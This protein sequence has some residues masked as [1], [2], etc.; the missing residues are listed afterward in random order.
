M[1]ELA[2]A[3]SILKL[4]M[5]SVL[6]ATSGMH[7]LRKQNRERMLAQNAMRSI[8]ERVH[9]RSHQLSLQSNTWAND[10]ADMFGPGGGFGNEFDVLGLTEA[11]GDA[12]V[13]TIQVITDETETDGT[14][15]S[16]LGMPRDLN[17]DGDT[18]DGDVTSDAVLLPVLLQVRWRGQSGTIT[19]NHAFYVLRY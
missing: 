8:A 14:L 18:L 10:L 19:L 5:V 6:S 9:A 3:I 11:D 2:I 15:D 12:V 1:I 13:G 16:Q 7:T 4:G 17:G